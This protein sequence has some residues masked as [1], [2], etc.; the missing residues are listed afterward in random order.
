MKQPNWIV[1]EVQPQENYMLLVTFITKEQ[2]TYDCKPILN[3]GIFKQLK[4]PQVF[5]LAHAQDGTVVWNDEVDI[6]PETLYEDGV[7]V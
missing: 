1:T 7:E 5:H 2:K 6:A 4:D 3:D